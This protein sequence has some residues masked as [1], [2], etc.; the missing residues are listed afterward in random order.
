[1]QKECVMTDFSYLLGSV[2]ADGQNAQ[3]DV[4]KELMRQLLLLRVKGGNNG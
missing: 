3:N 1:M 4:K 2:G